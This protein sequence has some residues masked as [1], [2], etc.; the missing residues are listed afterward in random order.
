M[1]PEGSGQMSLV[2]RVV[3]EDHHLQCS[4][5]ASFREMS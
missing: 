3:G 4:I 2:H 5:A 1:L